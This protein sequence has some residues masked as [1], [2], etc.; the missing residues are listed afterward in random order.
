MCKQYTALMG[1]PQEHMSHP[2]ME[3]GPTSAH[4]WGPQDYHQAG[5]TN[6]AMFPQVEARLPPHPQR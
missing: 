3:D 1:E 6:P 4:P 5:R 2:K